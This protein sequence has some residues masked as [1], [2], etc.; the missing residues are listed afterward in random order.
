[1]KKT[2]LLSNG[3]A[4]IRLRIKVNGIAVET[5]IKHSIS[6]NLWEQSPNH[7]KNVTGNWPNST[8]I[9]VWIGVELKAI[10]CRSDNGQ[11]L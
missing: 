4:P 2:Q 9:S 5:Q 8:S 10:H 3:E 6:P 7:L 11:T 1:M